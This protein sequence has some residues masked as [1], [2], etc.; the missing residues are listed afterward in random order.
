M[1]LQGTNIQLGVGRES[2]RGTYQAPSIWVPG[3]TPAGIQMQKDVTPIQETT[4]STVAS[5][6]QIVT[7]TRGEGQF[8]HNLR[9]SSIGYFFLSLFG[10]VTTSTVTTGVYQHIF[11]LLSGN[12]QYP[13][14]SLA[15]SQLAFQDYKYVRSIA[16]EIELV[17]PRDDLVQATVDFIAGAESTQA[18]FTPTLPS[19]DYFFR[20][21]DVSVKFAPL[22]GDLGAASATKLKELSLTV[23]NGARINQNIGELSG[24]DVLALMHTISGQ[25]SIDYQDETFHDLF[26][27]GTYRAMQITM[28][29]SDIDL[30]SSNPPSVVI[31]MPRV[32]FDSHESDRPLDELVTEGIGFSANFDLTSGYAIRATVVNGYAAYTT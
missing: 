29:R 18:D 5:T 2:T 23:N 21:Y 4:G 13:T 19:T 10:A 24:S 32:S 12:P 31:T 22:V 30:G 9:S 14:L 15:L 7:Q 3:R 1:F 20:P 27:A 17:F 28:T 16:R 26:A 6:G 25:L 11:N 8:E